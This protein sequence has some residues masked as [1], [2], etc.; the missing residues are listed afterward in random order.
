MKQIKLI[1]LLLSFL[2]IGGVKAQTSS[3]E[4]QTILPGTSNANISWD[5][6]TAYI[7]IKA[8]N[9]Y[10]ISSTHTWV[11]ATTSADGKKLIVTAD[12]SYSPTPR[13]ATITLKTADGNMTRTIKVTQEE[14]KTYETI[15]DKLIAPK[16]CNASTFQSGQGVERLFDKNNSTLWHS[17]YSASITASNPAVLTFNFSGTQT[18]NYMV[19]TPR[20][21]SGTNGIWK[22]YTIKVTDHGKT[23]TKTINSTAD[24]TPDTIRW[25]EPITPNKIEITITSGMGNFA[26]GAQL[27][28]YSDC[29]SREDLNIFAD[30]VYSTLREGVTQE[31]IDKLTNPFCKTIATGLFNGTY[32]T[33]YRVGTYPCRLSYD[34]LSAEWNAPGKRYSQIDNP[35]GINFRT[36][37]K[38]AVF[39]SGIP[40]DITAKLC[41]VAWY[42]GKDG[43]IFD[44]ADPHITDYT[45]K[46]GLNIIDYNYEWDG[47]AYIKYYANTRERYEAG[48]PDIKMHIVNGE[49]NGILTPDKTN[50]EMYELCKK[51]ASSGNI[52][53]DMLGSRVQSI[54]TSAGL[55]DYC[56]ASDGVALGYRQY[57][58]LL[59]SLVTWEH[60]QLGL[61]KYNRIPD[62]HTLAYTN[63]QYYMFQGGLGVSFHHD[64]EKRVLNCQTMMLKDYD[65]IWG[66]SHEWGHQHQMHPYACW[67]G[68]SEVSNNVFSY[69][70]VQ[71]LGYICN[72]S[73]KFATLFWKHQFSSIPGY[74]NGKAYSRLRNDSYRAAKSNSLLYSYSADLRNTCLAEEDSLMYKYEDNPSRSVNVYETDLGVTLAPFNLLGN[75]ATI[76][77]NYP[78]FYPDLFESLRQQNDFPGGS[79]VE[80]NNGFD[81]YELISAAQNG[82]VN[83]LYSM[84]EQN[85]PTSCWVTEN[86]LNKG[87][88]KWTDNSVPAL[89]CFIRKASRLYG[90]NL[91]NFFERA[92]FLRIGAYKHGDYGTK[93]LILTQKMLD[94]FKADM[95]AL[96]TDGT[97]KPLTDEMMHDIFYTRDFNVSSTDKIYPTPN[98]PN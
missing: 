38:K 51:A 35:T 80:K 56:K 2:I 28:F 71:H 12:T 26:S 53:I 57:L 89:F 13:T 17:N 36:G 88:V 55:R 25:E 92:G 9:Q 32:D 70:N 44:G 95:T 40:N 62:N 91:Y 76:Y 37:D 42:V 84:F 66:F 46:N 83:Q 85:Y 45:L 5:G 43:S 75:Y 7:P 77:L 16:I 79:T 65:A 87:K 86:Y 50:E 59:D 68:L 64:Q 1:P 20:Q 33:H 4:V 98:I 97:L 24:K 81:K 63:Y 73:K 90:Y 29:Q 78:D 31:D 61:E 3:N 69:Y 41:I 11:Q 10:S 21:D 22:T 52:C 6:Q 48:V 74:N 8:N 94:E 93:W 49:I 60:R 54:W 27:A 82:N 58:N 34:V 39:V 23:L 96:E 72:I 47:L 14:E 15:V 30:E 19:Y 18:I 67:G